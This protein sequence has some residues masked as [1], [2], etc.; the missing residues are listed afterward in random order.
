MLRQQGCD[1]LADPY[2][3]TA[4]ELAQRLVLT[5]VG[6]LTGWRRTAV[7]T[8]RKLQ[9]G[10]SS[11]RRPRSEMDFELEWADHFREADRPPVSARDDHGAREAAE[12]R[13][14]LGC[15]HV[16]PVRAQ[17]V[18]CLGAPARRPG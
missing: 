11:F 4:D 10:G 6:G 9:S 12:G 17:G 13:Q 3:E 16:H 7:A 1:A 5:G 2:A 14:V 18:E 8:E 15:V